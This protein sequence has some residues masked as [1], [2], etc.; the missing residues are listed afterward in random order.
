MKLKKYIYENVLELIYLKGRNI[1]FFKEKIKLN[2]H[3]YVKTYRIAQKF[4]ILHICL[5]IHVQTIT[6][7]VYP[8]GQKKK[9]APVWSEIG[10]FICIRHL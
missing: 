1:Y 6:K 10:I 9:S 5:G 4:T 2:L 7:F 3:Y 8:Y